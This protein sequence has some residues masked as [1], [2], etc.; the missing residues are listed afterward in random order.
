MKKYQVQVCV[1]Y[2]QVVEIEAE[3]QE[4][5]ECM[6]FYSFDLDKAHRGESECW[7]ISTEGETA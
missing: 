1:T 7:T 3:T 2:V 6:A 5:A 4:S